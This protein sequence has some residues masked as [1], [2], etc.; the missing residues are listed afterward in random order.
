MATLAEI[1]KKLSE[2]NDQTELNRDE[3]IGILSAFE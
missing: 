1:S 2:G 3:L